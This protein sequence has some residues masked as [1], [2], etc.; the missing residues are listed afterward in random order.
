MEPKHI[1]MWSV[2][3]G[4]VV[5]GTLLR[6][7]HE[8]AVGLQNVGRLVVG[9]ADTTTITT[10]TP[11]TTTTATVEALASPATRRRRQKQDS[12]SR[13]KLHAQ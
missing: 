13:G 3:L 2:I 12:P 7:W 6:F 10:P 4:G 11:T 8:I 9:R 1:V 5:V